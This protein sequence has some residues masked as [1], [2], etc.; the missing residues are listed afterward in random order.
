MSQKILI[1]GTNSGF[2]RLSAI[3]L[4]RK[5]HTVFATMRDIA[6][7]NRPAAEELQ[8]LAQTE[9]LKLHVLEMEVTKDASVESAVKEV[10]GKVE[11]LDVVVNNAGY[12]VMGLE[13][14]LTSEQL[15]EQFNVNVVGPH[16]VLR[17]VLPS[18]R[19]RGKGY[20]IHLSSVLGRVV[21]PVMG[22]YCAS[23]AALESLADAYSYELRPLGIESTIVQPGA[24]PTE[25]SSRINM[26]KEQERTQSYGPMADAMGQMR[27]ALQHMLK[28][29]GA[30]D[31]QDL[32]AALVQ[33]VE[34][35]PGS[36]PE[37][38]VVDKAS[39]QM[40]AALNAAHR[41]VQKGLLGAMGMAGSIG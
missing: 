24:F 3:A 35:A 7:R 9:G 32:A 21:F 38:L 23:K 10:L 33:L 26:G 19:A 41:E 8:R 5:G 13:E 28:G 20:L 6:G 4:A 2:G 1:T 12:G 14:T 17:A 22:A 11:A 31:P 39:P 18:M 27:T 16:R 25:F 36:R 34:S 40:A 37:R 29:P 30:Q 15:L